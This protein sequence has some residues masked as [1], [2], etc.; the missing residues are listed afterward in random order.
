[1][2]ESQ[3]WEATWIELE[4]SSATYQPATQEYLNSL[5]NNAYAFV[6]SFK[7]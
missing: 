4:S 2:N 1:M 6:S 3:V 7:D 5:I